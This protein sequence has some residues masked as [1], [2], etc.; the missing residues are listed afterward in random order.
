MAQAG[1]HALVGVA[2]R[3]WIPDR[4]WLILGI[5]LGNLFPDLD[6]Y[7]VAVAT[8]ARLNTHGLHRT[9]THSL[10]TILAAMTVFFVIAQVRRQPRW[11]NLGVGFGLGIGMHIALD[12]LIWFNGVALLWPWGGWVNLWEGVEPPAWFATLLDPVELLFFALYFVWLAKVAKDQHTNAD[13]LGALRLWTIAM[14][15]LFI[16][17][18]SL[19]YIMSQGFLTVF[20][21]V[22]LIS[23]TAAFII[24]IRMRQTVEIGQVKRETLTA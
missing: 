9:F 24:T 2:V 7:A 14:L 15:V 1:M 4:E 22:Y 21:A 20:G 11:T 3:K 5:I 13:F 23:I 19:A 10:F 17:F 16:V 12:L 8:V 6:N 18:T